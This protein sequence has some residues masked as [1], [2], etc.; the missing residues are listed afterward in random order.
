MTQV[1]IRLKNQSHATASEPFARL[2]AF[3]PELT[4]T[5]SKS[6]VSMARARF[7]S[8][9]LNGRIVSGE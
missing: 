9:A 8:R 2:S 6:P 4:G 7:A 1:N 5:A 3:D